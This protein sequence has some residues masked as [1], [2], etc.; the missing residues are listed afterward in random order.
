MYKI[1]TARG[2]KVT[3]QHRTTAHRHPALPSEE[4]EEKFP[5][6]VKYIW[7]FSKAK[8]FFPPRPVI[9]A[10]LIYSGF[11]RRYQF[12]PSEWPALYGR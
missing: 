10:H 3:L 6:D 8:G 1:F 2:E 5:E 4:M 12:C 11:E 9:A 7:T